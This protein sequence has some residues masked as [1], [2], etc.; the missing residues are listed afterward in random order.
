MHQLTG[1]IQHGLNVM[2]K[3]KDQELFNQISIDIRGHPNNYRIAGEWLDVYYKNIKSRQLFQARCFDKARKYL[4]KK[5]KEQSFI[6][7]DDARSIILMTCLLTDTEIEKADLNITQ[8]E[9]W[10]WKPVDDIFGGS[11]C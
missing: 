5:Y 1:I 10:P 6:P 7:E 2:D 9:K 4:A 3:D 11:R 8:F